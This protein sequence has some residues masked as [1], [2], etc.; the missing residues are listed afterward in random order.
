[1]AQPPTVQK[2]QSVSARSELTC[3]ESCIQAQSSLWD[4][5]PR[6]GSSSSSSNAHGQ[7]RQ[8][9]GIVCCLLRPSPIIAQPFNGITSKRWFSTTP[10][11]C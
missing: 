1:M 8:L 5:Q 9:G 6:Q 3:I 7:Q 2:L 10:L 4:L 11:G